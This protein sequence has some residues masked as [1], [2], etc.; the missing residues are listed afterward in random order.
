MKKIN[1]LKATFSLISFFIY[2]S[3]VA[4]QKT[5]VFENGDEINY[6]I[7]QNEPKGMN[8]LT[9]SLG[10]K[11]DGES[12]SFA[13]LQYF[14]PDK[15][16]LQSNIGVKHYE[17]GGLYFFNSTTIDKPINLTLRNVVGSGVTTRMQVKETIKKQIDF[18]IHVG[19]TY[20]EVKSDGFAEGSFV[21][22]STHEIAIGFGRLKSRYFSWLPEGNTK[23]TRGT[24][25][26]G[27]YADLLLYPTVKEG[28]LYSVTFDSNGNPIPAKDLVSKFG[29]RLYLDGRSSF[30]GTGDWGFIYRLGVGYG[31]A[32]Q[33]YLIIGYGIYWGFRWVK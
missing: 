24:V 30:V 29:G 32:K 4:Q 18:G 25:Q 22:L 33:T 17:I 15:F 20:K 10:A 5:A 11:F 7:I 16:F 31:L 14:R 9:M 6:E 26:T 1:Y 2:S 21:G 13:T 23:P 3:I 12:A 27:I 8:K 28:D 19:Y